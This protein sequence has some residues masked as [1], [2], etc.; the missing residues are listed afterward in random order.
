MQKILK[1]FGGITVIL[2]LIGAGCATTET[3]SVTTKKANDTK[4]ADPD[5]K[6]SDSVM[7]VEKIDSS[8]T[9]VNIALEST[10]IGNRQVKFEWKLNDG[11]SNPKYFILLRSE[12]QY[13]R[14]DQKTFWFRQHGTRNSATWINLPLGTQHFS[15]CTSDDGKTCSIYSND[16]VVE[17]I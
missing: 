10:A 17:V 13:P 2:V 6:I 8:A 3:T 11:E 16:S 1:F 15:I 7:D 9:E 5:T 4:S 12:K 14:H